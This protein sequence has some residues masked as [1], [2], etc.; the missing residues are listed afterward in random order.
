[1]AAE[2]DPVTARLQAWWNKDMGEV[3][4]AHTA[5][6]AR[7]ISVIGYSGESPEILRATADYLEAHKGT[8]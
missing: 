8:Q 1:M 3:V 4:A 6:E 7:E 2:D 5:A